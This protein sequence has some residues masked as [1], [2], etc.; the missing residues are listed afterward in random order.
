VGTV[1]LPPLGVASGRSRIGMLDL[2]LLRIS[3]LFPR[4]SSPMT[5]LVPVRGR[6]LPC[7]IGAPSEKNLTITVEGDCATRKHR[8]PA[9]P[10]PGGC[11]R[12][13]L[14]RLSFSPPPSQRPLPLA[15]GILGGPLSCR[16]ISLPGLTERGDVLYTKL[17]GV[18]FDRLGQGIEHLLQGRM[19]LR[20]ARGAKGPC[21]TGIDIDVRQAR[22]NVWA[23]IELR[24]ASPAG[25]IPPDGIGAPVPRPVN[26][27]QS[28]AV[29]LHPMPSTS[30]CS[31]P[32]ATQR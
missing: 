20:V 12:F 26:S 19:I 10:T 29:L 4:R 5:V 31:G 3:E 16:G 11:D 7:Q 15:P 27:G 8:P 24:S 30:Y 17:D 18:H 28:G 25:E 14:Q 22:A 1:L 9:M 23:S 21:R 13:S 6:L 2:N 32:V